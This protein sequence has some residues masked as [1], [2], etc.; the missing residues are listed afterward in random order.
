M[1]KTST[2]LRNVTLAL[3][4]AGV[5]MSTSGCAALAIGA[6]AALIE[7]GSGEADERKTEPIAAENPA[8]EKAKPVKK[9]AVKPTV[10]MAGAA[11]ADK[12]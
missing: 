10:Q 11:K 1:M 3:L 6:V 9:A 5:G 12:K 4:L 8:P 2:R 7:D